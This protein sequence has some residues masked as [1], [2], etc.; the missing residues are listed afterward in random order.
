M[1][2]P[3]PSMAAKIARLTAQRR[4]LVSERAALIWEGNPGMSWER[5]D[6]LALQQE[7][8]SQRPLPGL[9]ES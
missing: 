4:C 8:A 7:G 1:T 6:E 3:L 2:A 9:G 5:A